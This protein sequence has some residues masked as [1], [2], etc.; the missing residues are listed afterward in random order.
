[1]VVL[2]EG[3]G[4][5]RRRRRRNRRRRGRVGG[6]TQAKQKELN[7]EVGIRVEQG[8]RACDCE[9]DCKRPSLRDSDTQNNDIVPQKGEGREEGG[10]EGGS[11][12]RRRRRW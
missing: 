6:V 10:G 3:R 1:M 2:R 7:G 4:K 9:G 11:G 12:R 8:K 5:R